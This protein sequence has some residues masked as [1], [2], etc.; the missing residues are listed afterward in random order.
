MSLKWYI[1]TS[2]IIIFIFVHLAPNLGVN[3]ISALGAV[4][5]ILFLR[6]DY[7]RLKAEEKIMAQRTLQT[8]IE[9][10]VDATE[11]NTDVIG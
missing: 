5:L 1:F 6:G 7:K 4:L 8:T 11:E 10:K 2:I 9:I 3:I